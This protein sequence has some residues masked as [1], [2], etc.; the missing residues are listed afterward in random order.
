MAGRYE[1]VILQKISFEI[2]F[3]TRRIKRQKTVFPYVKKIFH[4]SG[5]SLVQLRVQN[6][7][8]FPQLK[9]HSQLSD[10]TDLDTSFLTLK[11]THPNLKSKYI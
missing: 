4:L 2:K 11:T 10:R 9:G 3:G 1:S 6:K 8:I 5:A 7:R